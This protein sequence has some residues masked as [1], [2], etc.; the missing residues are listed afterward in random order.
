MKVL[1]YG[2]KLLVSQNEHAFRCTSC[3]CSFTAE[4]SECV[5]LDLPMQPNIYAWCP[6]C[7]NQTWCRSDLEVR[8][9]DD[10]HSLDKTNIEV[11]KLLIDLYIHSTSPSVEDFFTRA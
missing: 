6:K 7:R 1:K 4:S 8:Y 9:E 5:Q 3:N 11:N 2:N 10:I